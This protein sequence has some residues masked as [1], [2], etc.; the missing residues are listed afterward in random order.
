MIRV[1]PFMSNGRQEGAPVCPS[2]RGCPCVSFKR[3][4]LCVLLCPPLPPSAPLCPPLPLSTPISHTLGTAQHMLR[5]HGDST[6]SGGRHGKS[7]EEVMKW[8]NGDAHNKKNYGLPK[9][10]AHSTWDPQGDRGGVGSSS[11]GVGVGGGFDAQY[12]SPYGYEAGGYPGAGGGGYGGGY[13]G[14]G[15]SSL[16]GAGGARALHVHAPVV[17]Y[18]LSVEVEYPRARKRHGNL[19]D[20]VHNQIGVRHV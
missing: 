2:L 13:G 15:R 18:H 9:D 3:A 8:W 1:E 6:T 16:R 11:G 5:L 17:Q 7:D 14:E 20:L 19:H 4:P 12:T 10:A